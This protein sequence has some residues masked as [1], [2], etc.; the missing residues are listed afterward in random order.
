MTNRNISD[1]RPKSDQFPILSDLASLASEVAV[2]KR[3]IEAL[4][5][6]ADFDAEI[7]R[8][9]ALRAAV[10]S[11]RAA[12]ICDLKVKALI[13]A[14]EVENGD[15]FDSDTPGC[16]PDLIAG[17]VRDI[18]SL[19]S[20]E[21]TARN[22]D[23]SIEQAATMEFE[24][25]PTPIEGD[26]IPPTREEWMAMADTH[27]IHLRIAW[28]MMERDKAALIAMV[29]TLGGDVALDLL[30]SLA[31]TARFLEGTAMVVREAE[32]RL[33]I[34]AAASLAEDGSN[35]AAARPD[36]IG[37]RDAIVGARIAGRKSGVTNIPAA[38]ATA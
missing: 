6:D 21:T 2:Q 36:T 25:W 31:S 29:E 8:L 11:T 5:G 4:P 9:W 23:P 13:M 26:W 32:S 35:E 10:A 1:F 16:A 27:A 33:T 22:S 28:K 15:S 38:T 14:E 34:A 24:P 19:P 7:D 18:L 12:S 17:V 3:R 30:D 37:A 20:S